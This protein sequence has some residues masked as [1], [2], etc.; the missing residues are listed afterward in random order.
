MARAEEAM[1]SR[2]QLAVDVVKAYGPKLR[3]FAPNELGQIKDSLFDG[4]T[5]IAAYGHTPGHTVYMIESNN[6]KLIVW[7]DLV[8]AMS[9]QMPNPEVAIKYDVDYKQAIVT[10]NKILKYIY[11]NKIS[12]AGIHIV[13]PGAGTIE[14]SGE[15]Y[16]FTAFDR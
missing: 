14:A 6:E 8:H 2:F 7:G 11:D 13:P 1:R 12:V 3:L 16:I 10:R 9:I 15:G 5:P 4:I